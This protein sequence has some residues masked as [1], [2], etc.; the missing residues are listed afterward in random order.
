MRGPGI[1]ERKHRIEKLAARVAFFMVAEG[2]AGDTIFGSAFSVVRQKA[3]DYK[4]KLELAARDS[5]Q[6]SLIKDLK[7]RGYD[8][9]SVEISLGKYRGSRFVTSAKVKVVTKDIGQAKALVKILQ[10]YHSNY[11]LKTFDPETKQAEYNIR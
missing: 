11:T 3:R 7:D 5:L 9:T 6:D 10:G 1:M 8:V 4:D 2:Q